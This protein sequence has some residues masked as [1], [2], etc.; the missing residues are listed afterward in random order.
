MSGSIK[1][2]KSGS[3]LRTTFVLCLNKILEPRIGGGNLIYTKKQI[4]QYLDRSQYGGWI[5]NARVDQRKKL[6]SVEEISEALSTI[7]GIENI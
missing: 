2:F 5:Q 3:Y 1:T 4:E 6:Q 7:F